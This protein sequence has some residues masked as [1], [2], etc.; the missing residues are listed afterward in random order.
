MP[1]QCVAV[2]PNPTIESKATDFGGTGDGASPT[3]D[4]V[5]TQRVEGGVTLTTAYDQ[6]S[7]LTQRDLAYT[8]SCGP[9]DVRTNY[10]FDPLNN[11]EAMLQ[12]HTAAAAATTKMGEAGTTNAT[13]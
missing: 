8:T 11:L 6:N 9:S 3:S 1:Q 12:V 13:G 5:L 2:R 4:V 10:A 7:N